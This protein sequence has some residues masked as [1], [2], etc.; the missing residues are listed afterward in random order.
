M[1]AA[2]VY[3][4]GELAGVLIRHNNTKYEFI[5]DELW[6]NNPQKPAV[7]LTLPKTKK[8]HHSKH[9]FP[10][11]FNLLSEGVNLRLQSRHHQIDEHNYFDLLLATA[12]TDTIGAITVKPQSYTK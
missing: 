3:R 9:L 2:N 7:S 8:N 6:F 11:F 5:Y 4:N 12:H 1:R 10:F